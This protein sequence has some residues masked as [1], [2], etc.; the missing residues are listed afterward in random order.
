MYFSPFCGRVRDRR[1]SM[2]LGPW[3][4]P[5]L[6]QLKQLFENMFGQEKL[7]MGGVVVNEVLAQSIWIT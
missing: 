3:I 1:L 5:A 4:N 7:R 6:I 2:G